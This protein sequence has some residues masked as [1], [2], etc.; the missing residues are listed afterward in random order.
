MIDSSSVKS[1]DLEELTN[2]TAILEKEIDTNMA[3]VNNLDDQVEDLTQR[4]TLA[5]ATLKRL[6]NRTDALQE[7]ATDL[8]EN[9][10]RLQESNVQGALNVTQQM[11]GQ[12]RRAEK[13]AAE[14]D[15]L[16][17]DAERFKKN[18]ENLLVKSSAN[19]AESQQRNTESLERLGLKLDSL[20]E[21]VP[22][23]NMLMCGI[24]VD[25]CS[26]VCGGAGCGTCGGLS[27]DMG[28]MTKASQALDVAKKQAD[29]IKDRKDEAEQLLRSVSSLL[30]SFLPYIYF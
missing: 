16:L 14:T 25:D 15:G 5:D 22:D 27:C 3:V 18:T 17:L 28:A 21:N 11:A 19:V 26:D 23:L 6:K 20:K 12:S 8:R 10:N 1:Q 2:S 7:G 29:K 30:N 4:V 24:S 9:A 13:M